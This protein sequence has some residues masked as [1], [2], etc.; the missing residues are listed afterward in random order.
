MSQVI[1]FLEKLGQDAT[2]RHAS[3]EQLSEEIN[4]LDVNDELRDAL[5]NND[6]E[7]LKKLLGSRPDVIC[8]IAPAEDEPEKEGDD[9]PDDKIRQA[10]N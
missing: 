1:K 10:V 7:A 2:L 5:Q 8:F 4:Q 9:Q 6:A 3:K